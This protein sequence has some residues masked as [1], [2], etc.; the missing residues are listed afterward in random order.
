MS[1]RGDGTRPGAR[2]GVSPPLAPSQ[3][4]EQETTSAETMGRR[5]EAGRQGRS[6][7][8]SRSQS[9]MRA[10]DDVRRDD[11]ATARGRAPECVFSPPSRSQSGMRAG[12]DVRPD[13]TS[14]ETSGRW[15]ETGR[16]GRSLPS[17]RSQSGIRAGDDVRRDDGAT[18][19][20]RAPGTESP[21]LSLPVRDAIRRR[22]PLRRLG[23]G[24][25]PGARDG[26]S[27]PLAPSQGCE[28]ETTSA[29]TT[30]RQHEAGR[31]G[32]SL[33]SSRSQSGMRAGDDVRRDDGATARGRA[34]ECVFSPPSRSESGM[35]R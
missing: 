5:H 29:E 7:Q 26:V 1:C 17:S 23:D 28:Q 31:Q 24:T 15:H 25:R 30:G 9:G 2:D 34:P 21:L 33:H 4:C 18:A 3:G 8:S 27:P 32:R 35:R 16:Q 6:L 20:D 13:V 14:A 22:R 19:R 11:G 12:D 10:G